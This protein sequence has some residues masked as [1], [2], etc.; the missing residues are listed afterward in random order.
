MNH[1]ALALEVAEK[2]HAG[3]TDK[4]GQPYILHPIRVGA[5]F[6][7]TDLQAIGFLHDVLEDTDVTEDELRGMFPAR[8]VDAV[9]ALSRQDGEQYFDFIK[10]C[11]QNPLAR[12]V[13]VADI[14]DNLRPGYTKDSLR[15]RYV[16]A[17]GILL[18][19]ADT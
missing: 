10:R 2:A 5:S 12:K 17:L 19:E 7:S 14:R 18:D 3:V 1:A 4:G 15:R 8:I 9:Y 11:R 13:K 6:E 16:S